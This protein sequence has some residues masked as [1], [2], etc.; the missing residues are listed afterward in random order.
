MELILGVAD[1]G[2]NDKGEQFMALASIKN[3]D[4][5]ELSNKMKLD[6][7]SETPLTADLKLIVKI[8]RMSVD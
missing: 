6:S 1:S 5:K 3:R 7:E 4:E 8:L 2:L